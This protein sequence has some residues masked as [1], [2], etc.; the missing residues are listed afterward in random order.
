MARAGDPGQ[1][2][3]CSQYLTASGT[4]PLHHD[5]PP[6]SSPPTFSAASLMRLQ[7]N[8]SKSLAL[9]ATAAGWCCS[10]PHAAIEDQIT[11]TEMRRNV[12]EF[13]ER[14]GVDNSG[15]GWDSAPRWKRLP[16]AAGY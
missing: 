7:A 1:A 13:L 12:R 3:D 8:S 4:K 14:L 10:M 6:D 9:R 2:V 5:R 11:Q 16:L 15:Y